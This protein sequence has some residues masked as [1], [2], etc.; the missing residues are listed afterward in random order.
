M[1]PRQSTW[2]GRG[3]RVGLPSRQS[4]STGHARPGSGLRAVAESSPPGDAALAPRQPPRRR[5]GLLGA[6]SRGSRHERL[7]CGG[8][9]ARRRQRGA[10]RPSSRSRRGRQRPRSPARGLGLRWV[11]T[12]L[13]GAGSPPLRAIPPR[14]ERSRLPRSSR[15]AHRTRKPGVRPRDG[16]RPRAFDRRQRGQVHCDRQRDGAP[17]HP[18]PGRPRARAREQR[19]VLV[20]R[21]LRR[22]GKPDQGRGAAT[23]RGRPGQPVPQHGIQQAVEIRLVYATQRVRAARALLRVGLRARRISFS[24]PLFHPAYPLA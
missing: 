3:R 20:E 6:P 22:P 8:S 12:P 2:T 10:G 9:R 15:R 7:H 11:A 1:R 13:E 19:C 17:K 24:A 5:A 21:G 14:R 18:A 23:S 16:A 4:A